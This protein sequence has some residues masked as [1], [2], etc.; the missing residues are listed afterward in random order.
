MGKTILYIAMS[1]DSYG[2]GVC[3]RLAVPERRPQVAERT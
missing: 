2:V 3:V 1:L